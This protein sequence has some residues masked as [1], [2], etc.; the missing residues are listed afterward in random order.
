M[1]GQGELLLLVIMY[2]VILF[3]PR[4]FLFCEGL[5]LSSLV[6]LG[7]GD[8]ERRIIGVNNTINKA[9]IAGHHVLEVISDKDHSDIQL[10]ILGCLSLLVGLF[11]GLAVRIK[12]EGLE[13]HLA[14]GDEVGLGLGS[15]H[16]VGGGPVALVVLS[17]LNLIRLPLPD[18]L[19]TQDILV[20]SHGGVLAACLGAP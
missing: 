8:I 3:L 14:L 4:V 15:V 13:G 11:R 18:G 9:V 20:A 1:G 16:A 5:E 10:D 12:E 19:D 17:L 6:P 2:S 7:S